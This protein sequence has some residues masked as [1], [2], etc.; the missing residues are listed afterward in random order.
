MG[1][2]PADLAGHGF[3][4]PLGSRAAHGG[5]TDVG[6]GSLRGSGVSGGAVGSFLAN[7]NRL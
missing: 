5:G 1:V 6:A 7:H 3:L 4:Q 2:A